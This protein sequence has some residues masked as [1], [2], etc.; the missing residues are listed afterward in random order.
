MSAST[1][2]R[3]VR[4]DLLTID[5]YEERFLTPLAK[6]V[7]LVEGFA[8]NIESTVG[9]IDPTIWHARLEHPPTVEELGA[10][11][12]F[13]DYLDRQLEGAQGHAKKLRAAFVRLDYLRIDGATRSDVESVTA[14]PRRAGDDA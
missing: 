11:T 3:E 5:E 12:L 7:A 1:T 14:R 6:V 10:Y 4:L 9:D 13:V 2:S 8:T